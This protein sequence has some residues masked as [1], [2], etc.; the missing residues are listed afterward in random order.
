MSK[1]SNASDNTDKTEKMDDA[2]V[3]IDQPSAAPPSNE[4]KKR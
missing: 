4:T 1:K 2:P 3:S